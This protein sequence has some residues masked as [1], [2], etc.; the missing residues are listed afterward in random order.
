MRPQISA[1][2]TRIAGTV[3]GY[4][5]IDHVNLTV[6]VVV[7]APEIHIAV[8]LLES[9]VEDDLRVTV[10]LV[11]TSLH[12][13]AVL[14]IGRWIGAV[15]VKWRSE[16]PPGLVVEV[17]PYAAG[18]AHVTVG[19]RVMV[20]REALAAEHRAIERLRIVAGELLV[21]EVQQNHQT[22]KVRKVKVRQVDSA[23]G[24][25]HMSL[26]D[27]CLIN[28]ALRHIGQ[29]IQLV[30]TAVARIMGE[31]AGGFKRLAVTFC[32]YVGSCVVKHDGVAVGGG[33][34]VVELV[35]HKADP[36]HRAVRLRHQYRTRVGRVGSCLEAHQYCQHQ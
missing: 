6:M 26:G 35:S 17:V 9:V 5:K 27:S 16:R 34:E 31:Q 32:I 22:A 14:E 2:V 25:T 21:R 10:A 15:H 19:N 13:N 11:R 36:Q 7:I 28:Q 4:Q 24:T 29:E 3:T 18:A 12:G 30:G 1:V 23:T 8:G 20:A 33:I